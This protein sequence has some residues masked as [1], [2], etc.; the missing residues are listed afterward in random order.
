MVPAEGDRAAAPRRAP[1]TGR[2]RWR[3]WRFQLRPW[4]LWMVQVSV[5]LALSVW[6]AVIIL[7]QLRQSMEWASYR[8][9]VQELSDTMRAMRSR[10][11][12][13]GQGFQLRIDASRGALYVASLRGGAHPYDRIER[14]IWLPEGLRISEAPGAVTVSP[15]GRM[16][17]A[18]LVIA[19]PAYQ[20]S[21][22]LTT[23]AQG[24]VYLHEEPVS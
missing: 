14:T 3:Y 11:V 13:Q 15:T 7:P 10:A 1:G 24:L 19:A 5:A 4:A 12:T 20:R 16:S 17:P 2:L 9:T 23:D 6:L 18:T 22:R 21:F 8:T